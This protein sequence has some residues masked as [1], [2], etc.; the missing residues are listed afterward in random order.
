MCNSSNPKELLG[1]FLGGITRRNGELMPKYK[2]VLTGIYQNTRDIEIEI[3]VARFITFTSTELGQF[4][5]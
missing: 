3:K 5:E 4:A 1:N 2:R